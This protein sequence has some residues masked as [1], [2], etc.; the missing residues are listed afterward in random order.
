MPLTNGFIDIINVVHERDWRKDGCG[1][2][3]LGIVCERAVICISEQFIP[4]I[5]DDDRNVKIFVDHMRELV[6]ADSFSDSENGFLIKI[7]DVLQGS[8]PLY[9]CDIICKI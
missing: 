8:S 2:D 6:R 9:C 7:S 1:L 3:E 5:H 4:F